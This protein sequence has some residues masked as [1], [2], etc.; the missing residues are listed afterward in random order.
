MTSP[1]N[2]SI[3]PCECEKARVEAN[4]I[5]RVFGDCCGEIIEPDFPSAAG[6]R[7][8][9][10]G[11]AAHE[12]FETLAVRELQIHFAAMTFHETERV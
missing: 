3:F 8:K 6:Q 9:S 5:A 11:V 4:Q 10:V 12:G 7:F 1:W 2:E